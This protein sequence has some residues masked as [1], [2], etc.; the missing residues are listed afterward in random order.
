MNKLAR[1]VDE[2]HSSS[3][4]QPGSMTAGD[5]GDAQAVKAGIDST[6]P[7]KVVDAPV[8][9]TRKR[10]SDQITR[11]MYAFERWR[12]SRVNRHCEMLPLV[13]VFALGITQAHGASSEVNV[14][15]RDLAFREAAAGVE[16]DFKSDPHP[17]RFAA[18]S[19]PQSGNLSISQFRLFFLCNPA[20]TELGNRIGF[21]ELAPDSLVQQLGEK[22]DFQ[23]GG[24]VTDPTP[25]NR[26]R[27]APPQI[28]AAMRVTH[29]SGIDYPFGAQER[30][31]SLPSGYVSALR[32]CFRAPMLS[33]ITGY[34][35]GKSGVVPMRPD[36]LLL[37]AGLGRQSLGFP[38]IFSGISPQ[39][40][41]GFNPSPG[42]QFTLAQVPKRRPSLSPQMGH[43]GRVAYGIPCDKWITGDS[44]WGNVVV[45]SGLPILPLHHEAPLFPASGTVSLPL[46]SQNQL[47]RSTLTEAGQ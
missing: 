8:L 4:V 13:C 24:I 40:G 7:E 45:Y 19:G 37:S 2:H 11:P 17:F 44:V 46:V 29:L 39:A 26:G 5:K 23:E 36:L 16:A 30:P 14:L 28:G 21:T 25:M 27:H 9:I 22:L 34:P 20:N 35:D 3:L 33:E 47:N 1:V 6:L 42:I 32:P 38:S 43:A 31:E 12:K 10:T 15:H 18:Q 41:A